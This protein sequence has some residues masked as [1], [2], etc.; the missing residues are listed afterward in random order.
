MRKCLGDSVFDSPNDI[1]NSRPTGQVDP[2]Q[3]VSPFRDQSDRKVPT[4]AEA[5]QRRRHG[6]QQ[7]RVESWFVTEPGIA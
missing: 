2:N 5:V 6:S 7:H 1:G 4:T 3:G